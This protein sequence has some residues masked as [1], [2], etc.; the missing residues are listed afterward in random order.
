MNRH[1]PTIPALFAALVLTAASS[2]PSAAAPK[3]RKDAVAQRD[4]PTLADSTAAPHYPER[5]AAGARPGEVASDFVKIPV[6]DGPGGPHTGKHKSPHGGALV[7]IGED[8]AHLEFALNPEDGMLTMYVWDGEAKNPMYL[9]QELVFIQLA[10]GGLEFPIVLFQQDDSGMAQRPER[11][12]RYAASHQRL[13]GVDHFD[14]LMEGV[15]F[16][17]QSYRRI[18]FTYPEGTE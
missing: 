14:A 16:G 5:T 12:S 1:R 17:K 10:A 15:T 13:V 8:V 3:D 4:A 18:P 9:P 6:I 2:G 7:P 11:A